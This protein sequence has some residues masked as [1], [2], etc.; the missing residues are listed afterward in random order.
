MSI[1]SNNDWVGA[2]RQQ[3]SGSTK[4]W[5][6]TLALS[7][8]FGF[9]GVDRFYLGSTGLGIAKLLTCGGFG[10]WWAIDVVLLLCGQMKD[11]LGRTVQR[12]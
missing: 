6:V 7:G 1:G 2:L 8:I 3:H 4:S 9:L 11:D 12:K 10:A 5:T